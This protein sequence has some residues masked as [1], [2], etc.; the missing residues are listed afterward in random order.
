[1]KIVILCILF[2]TVIPVLGQK[3]F[4]LKNASKYFDIKLAVA[5]CDD[6][7]CRGRATF[8]FYKKG[9]STP[10]QLINLP[11]T[12]VQLESGGK[13]LVNVNLLYDAQSVV[14]VGDFNFDGMEDVALCDGENGSYGAPSYRVY[15]SSRAA[16]KFVFNKPL[17]DLGRHL[18]MFTVDAKNKTLETFDKSGCCWHITERY[19]VV[20]NRPV[21]V[22]EEVEDATVDPGGK[23]AKVTTK[24]LVSGKWQKSVRFEKIDQ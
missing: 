13:P 9:A 20:N 24:K 22:F 4:E 12:L 10:Y 15:L 2:F 19:K 23:R 17:T 7:F 11:D 21:K 18:S 3:T 14:N 1:M 8:S 5:K 6:E 16:G